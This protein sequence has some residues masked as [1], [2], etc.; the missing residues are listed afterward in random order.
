MKAGNLRPPPVAPLARARVRGPFPLLGPAFVAGIAYVDPGNF[1]TNLSAGAKYGYLLV[2]VVVVGNLMAML[3]Q[4]LSAKSGIATGRNLPELCRS[5][6]PLPVVRGL[7][8]QAEAISI[9]TD[10]AEVLGGAI[11]LQL[12]FDV[13]L[14]VGGVITAGVAFALLTLQTRGHRPFET[15]ITGLLGVIL[16]GFL[17]NV[18]AAGVSLGALAEG[19]VPRFDGADSLLLATGML[20]ATVM[21]QRFGFL[22]PSQEPHLTEAIRLAFDLM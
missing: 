22:R 7:W 2:W 11:A 19:V 21:P 17:Y 12:L 8:V 3:I 1:A 9:A 15:A 18:V 6:F 10:L 16:L 5:Q 14:L 13:P 4:Y 20:G